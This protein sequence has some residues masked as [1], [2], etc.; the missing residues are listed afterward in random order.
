MV[1]TVLGQST[2]V[3]LGDRELGRK[4]RKTQAGLGAT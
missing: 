3:G 2:G 4:E 1:K